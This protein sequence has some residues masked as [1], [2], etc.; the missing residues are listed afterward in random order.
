LRASVKGEKATLFVIAPKVGG[1]KDVSGTDVEADGALSASPSIFFDAVV[2]LASEMGATDLATQAAAINWVADA[3][4]HLKVIGHTPE[5]QVL[6]DKA[7]VVA[8]SGILPV[9]SRKSIA[10]YIEAAKTSR[11][12]ER[13]PTLR[14]P[15]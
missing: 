2:I 5:T 6:L 3:F 10:A 13:E 4:A 12:W 11:I 1:V 14:R 8:D 15:G 7:C 9:T